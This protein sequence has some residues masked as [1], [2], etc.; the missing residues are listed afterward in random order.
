MAFSTLIEAMFGTKT[1]TAGGNRQRARYGADS[2]REAG[3]IGGPGGL[4][5][6]PGEYTGGAVDFAVRVRKA[7]GNVN[8]VQGAPRVFTGG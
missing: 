8:N 5:L 2:R 7:Q 6:A 4:Q 1:A 3:G